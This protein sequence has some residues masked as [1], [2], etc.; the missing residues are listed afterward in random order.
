M[1]EVFHITNW[2]L[3]SCYSQFELK[4]SFKVIKQ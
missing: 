4:K 2:E 1:E 3:N